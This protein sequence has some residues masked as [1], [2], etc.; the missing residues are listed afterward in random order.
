MMIKERMVIMEL[1]QILKAARKVKG[2]TQDQVSE[3][4]GVSKKTIGNYERGLHQPAGSK[5]KRLFDIYGLDSK[6]IL[7]IELPGFGKEVPVLSMD[8]SYAT[9][10]EVFMAKDPICFEYGDT[11]AL[12]ANGNCLYLKV[13]N[14]SMRDFRIM[15]G[16]LV[17]FEEITTPKDKELIVVLYEKK[18]MVRQYRKINDESFSLN[19]SK[20]HS[21]DSIVIDLSA[22][23]QEHATNIE[24]LGAVRRIV[25]IP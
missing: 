22:P 3:L 18:M 15:D 5:M 13:N 4:T 19:T 6:D 1:H 12:E 11:K 23:V 17:F 8:R 2:Y 16:D 14:D 7:G 10:E 24:I 25:L 9:K 21:R 20:M